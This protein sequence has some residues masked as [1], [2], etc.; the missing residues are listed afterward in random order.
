MTQTVV[1]TEHNVVNP[2]STDSNGDVVTDSSG[3]P[4]GNIIIN[5]GAAQEVTPEHLADSNQGTIAAASG[6][7]LILG[8]MSPYG[9]PYTNI[10][11]TKT[12]ANAAATVTWAVSTNGFLVID[13]T[14]NAADSIAITADNLNG[15]TFANNI[16]YIDASDGTIKNAALT[17]ATA[18]TISIWTGR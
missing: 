6:S 9:I 14:M 8:D 15:N 5:S 7:T 18:E 16:M 1:T 4:A 12:G 3:N 10:T 17:G 2:V 11:L 13:I